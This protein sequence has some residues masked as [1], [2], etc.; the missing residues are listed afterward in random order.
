MVVVPFAL[1]TLLPFPPGIVNTLSPEL[2]KAPLDPAQSNKPSILALLLKGCISLPSCK[3]GRN[4]VPKLERDAGLVRLKV[5][6][7]ERERERKRKSERRRESERKREKDRLGRC[8]LSAVFLPFHHP[9][10]TPHLHVKLT[11]YRPS[12][13]L[14]LE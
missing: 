4:K 3:D 12:L 7:G 5:R 1:N 9:T 11:M 13:A 10:P 14:T 6:R 8:S 2:E